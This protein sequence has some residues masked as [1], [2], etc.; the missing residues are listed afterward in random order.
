[1][2]IFKLS[3]VFAFIFILSALILGVSS[4][5]IDSQITPILKLTE[6]VLFN[7]GLVFLGINM[8]FIFFK[9]KEYKRIILEIFCIVIILTFSLLINLK[10]LAVNYHIISLFSFLAI[11]FSR[12]AFNSK[13]GTKL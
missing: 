3:K 1:M 2:T 10:I 8:I 6:Q 11:I 9:I 7:L 4:R 13:Y 12:N 5:F